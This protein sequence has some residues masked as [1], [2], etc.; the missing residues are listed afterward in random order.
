MHSFK[1]SLA[2]RLPQTQ[3]A[4]SYQVAPYSMKHNFVSSQIGLI[5]VSALSLFL[6]NDLQK[7]GNGDT[8][9]PNLVSTTLTLL[10]AVRCHGALAQFD[11]SSKTCQKRRTMLLAH[12]EKSLF[13]EA[14]QCRMN[15]CF[16]SMNDAAASDH[17]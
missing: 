9:Q 8:D 13:Q 11:T 10:V 1:L 3:Q 16:Q 7:V 5:G 4:L 12:T 2:L 14:A 6:S 15:R 17:V